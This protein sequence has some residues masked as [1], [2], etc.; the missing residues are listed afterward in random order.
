MT[1]SICRVVEG[2]PECFCPAGWTG[3]RCH[4]H[5]NSPPLPS[6]DIPPLLNVSVADLNIAVISLAVTSF[7]LLVLVAALAIVIFRLKQRPRIVRKR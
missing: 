4:L 3:D 2:A 7:V 5:Q 6:R 1:V